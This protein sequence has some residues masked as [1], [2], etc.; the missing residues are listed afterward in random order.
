M[1]DD[2][3]EESRTVGFG[4]FQDS[5]SLDDACRVYRELIRYHH[6]TFTSDYP[7]EA[8]GEHDVVYKVTIER[9]DAPTEGVIDLT[10][11]TLA[12]FVGGQLEVQNRNEGYLYRG[13]IE[14]A[15]VE[16]DE[17]R[18]TLKWMAKGEGFPLLPERWVEEEPRDYVVSLGAYSVTDPGDGRLF[19]T[20][21]IFNELTVLFPPEHEN[22]L[23]RS[24]IEEKGPSE[25]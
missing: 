20:S 13:E 1:S 8:V 15:L 3:V 17:F 19:L 6:R 16:D 9:V 14:T 21:S 18:A 12:R 22:R 4:R 5:Q 23:D 24:K 11:E 7:T 2:I 10:N 25:S